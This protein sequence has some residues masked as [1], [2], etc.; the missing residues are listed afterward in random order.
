MWRTDSLEKPWCWERLKAGGEGDDRGWDGFMAS[1]TQWK[2]VWV[3]FG[4]WW[5]TGMPDKLQYMGSQSR[6]RLSD[7]TELNLVVQ[8]VENLPAIWETWFDPWVGKIPW[9]RAWQPTPVLLPGKFLWTEEPG[10]LQ[11]MGL[12]KVGHDWETKHSTAYFNKIKY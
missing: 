6:M 12:Q 11:S 8:M 5:W 4:S 2:W 9:R 10:G 1:L 3:N 7:W